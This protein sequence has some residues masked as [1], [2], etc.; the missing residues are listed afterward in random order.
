MEIK[1]VDKQ[2]ENER[3]RLMDLVKKLRDLG[4]S[5]NEIRNLSK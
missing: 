1:G 5:D 4:V 3:I 2:K